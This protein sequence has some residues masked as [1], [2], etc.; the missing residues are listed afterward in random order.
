M[1]HLLLV[2][3]LFLSSCAVGKKRSIRKVDYDL[4]NNAKINVSYIRQLKDKLEFNLLG[5]STGADVLAIRKDEISCGLGNES[6][7]EV[8]VKNGKKDFII[9][10]KISFVGFTVI[11]KNDEPVDKKL[12][13]YLIFKKVYGTKGEELGPVVSTDHRID[14]K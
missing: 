6:F 12:I 1:N 3:L 8:K 11:C 4:G 14:I 2:F 7:E 10:P 13:P 9:L 5:L